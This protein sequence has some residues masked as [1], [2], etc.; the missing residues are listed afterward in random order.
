MS[1]PTHTAYVV[2]PA[3][4]G[5]ETQPKWKPK[6]L[7]VGTVWPHKNGGGFDLVIP[8]GISLRGRIVITE[9]LHEPRQHSTLGEFAEM[10][11]RQGG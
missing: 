10:A 4:E 6:W 11:E 2:I 7:E 5:S 3:K 1:R 9:R 8:K